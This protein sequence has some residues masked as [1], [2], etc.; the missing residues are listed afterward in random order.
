MPSTTNN[1]AATAVE[2]GGGQGGAKRRGQEQQGDVADLAAE[3]VDEE[4]GAEGGE[5]LAACAAHE[6]QCA[7]QPIALAKPILLAKLSVARKT[8]G[9]GR[10]GNAVGLAFRGA[11]D[12]C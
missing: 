3:A 11:V 9:E 4:E 12:I 5:D 1:R 6:C 2:A 10:S 7:V 8:T